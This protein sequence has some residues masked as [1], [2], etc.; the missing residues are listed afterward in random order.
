MSMR[1]EVAV[2]SFLLP[3]AKARRP[4]GKL[5]AGSRDSR[6]GAGATKCGVLFR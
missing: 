2:G 4:Y 3:T 6:Q 5:R 1:G